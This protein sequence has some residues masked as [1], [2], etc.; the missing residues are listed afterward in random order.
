[1][2]LLFGETDAAADAE[3]AMIREAIDT[4]A[5][6][7]LVASFERDNRSSYGER[8][9]Y[10]RAPNMI[11][12]GSGTP[13]TGSPQTIAE[14]LAALLVESGI[15]GIQLTFVDYVRDLRIFGE[16]VLPFLK[17]LLARHD[18]QVGDVP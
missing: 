13:V 12:F 18:I 10:L 17:R 8:S 5:V 6:D 2:M 3:F 1:M 14:K 15:E 11:G 9:A 7:N 4:E 16:H